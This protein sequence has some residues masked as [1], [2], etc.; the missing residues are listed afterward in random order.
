MRIHN[1]MSTAAIDDDAF[2]FETKIRWSSWF[3]N[4]TMGFL[5]PIAP[6]TSTE[7][8]VDV[9]SFLYS[10]T[11]SASTLFYLLLHFARKKTTL[12]FQLNQIIGE[13]V[14]GTFS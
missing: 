11:D 9:Y 7:C 8:V 3:T 6:M 4:D 2:M 14:P 13:L 10:I 12:Q 5:F 1:D